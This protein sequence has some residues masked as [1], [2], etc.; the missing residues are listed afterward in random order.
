[1]V[2]F[3]AGTGGNVAARRG[4]PLLG[5]NALDAGGVPAEGTQHMRL[6]QLARLLLDAQIEYFLPCLALAGRRVP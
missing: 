1:M 2:S 4:L 3:L 5:E 6:F